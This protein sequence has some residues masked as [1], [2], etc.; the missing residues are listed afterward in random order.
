MSLK[1]LKYTLNNGNKLFAV[2]LGTWLLKGDSLLKA[3]DIAL[4]AGYRLFDTAAM[5]GNE[6]D[7]GEAL[8]KL[9][10]KHNLKREDVFITTKLY[11][12]EQGDKAFNAIK[13]SLDKLDCQ[14][15]D[16]YLIHWPGTYGVS[17][18]SKEN[19]VLR[20]LSWQHMVKAVNLGLI[21]NIGVS[22][23]TTK[24]LKELLNNNHGIKPV[25]NQIEWHPYCHQK[26]LY[27]FCK[28]ENIQLQAYQSLGGEGN[29]DLLE[30]KVIKD[31][32]AKLGKTTGQLLLRW[33]I[34]QN[35]AIIPKSKTKERIIGNMELDF[36]I[37]EEDMKILF[38]FKQHKYDWDPET[39]FFFC[40][41]FPL[42]MIKTWVYL[43]PLF[44]FTFD[45]TFSE[46]NQLA[47]DMK[48][49]LH[50]GDLMPMVG[51]GTY[52]IRGDDL[53]KTTLDYALGAGYR[54]I[55]SAAV[56]GNEESI[57]KALKELLPKYN[58]TRKDIFIT[59][60]LAPS[61]QGEKAYSALQ[62]SL[63]NLDCE[64]LDLY[65]IHW[66]GAQGIKSEGKNNS[67]LRDESWQQMVK[68]VK[69]G[70]VRNIGVS[71]YNVNHM[72]QLLNNNHGIKPAVNQV[73][74]HPHYH[75]DDL[76]ELLKKEGILLQ[77]YSS[78]GGNDNNQHLLTDPEVIKIAT[79]LGK[80]PA[81]VLLRWALQQN[82]AVIPKARSK[83]HIEENFDL[84]FT[85]P[86]EDMKILS[87]FS[88]LKYA[89]DPDTIA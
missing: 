70:L 26:I 6:K 44:L 37:P 9:L 36:N 77:T 42:T 50:S 58:L 56:Y 47:K 61:D 83:K 31:I 18:N 41:L 49:T 85:I 66:P 33:S 38:S 5:Y 30:N 82:L 45:V 73:E 29:N 3:M 72:K 24:H 13:E 80:S 23:Y 48:F 69:N 68:G 12:S 10:P 60:K 43:V 71:N 7:L 14:Y 32:A 20:D 52:L 67:V 87:N 63:N 51:F 55:D 59:T 22:N 57:G 46:K 81:Q 79:K 35:I 75:Q 86:E 34:Q 1:D 78:L 21:K 8:K 89:W 25:V 64:Y 76:Q 17:S 2:G 27:D 28:T 53:I 4:E 19:T 16:L 62:K 88:Q 11:P 74:W 40:F 54:L 84:D 65:L 15:I 39:I